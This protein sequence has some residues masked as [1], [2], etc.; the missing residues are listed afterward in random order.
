MF[1]KNWCI[2]SPCSSRSTNQG[3]WSSSLSQDCL[4]YSAPVDFV[5]TIVDVSL[6][7]SRVSLLSVFT[8]E[9]FQY[10]A[11]RKELECS[12]RERRERVLA[13]GKDTEDMSILKSYRT[14]LLKKAI[15]RFVFLDSA[16]SIPS[17]ADNRSLEGA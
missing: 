10:V 13:W 3:T 11:F 14:L 9:S 15:N 8:K 6:V 16:T 1:L 17:V 5:A 4:Q 12:E 7:C 2:P